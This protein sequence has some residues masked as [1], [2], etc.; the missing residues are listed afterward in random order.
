MKRSLPTAGKRARHHTA[1]PPPHE[2]QDPGR[3]VISV[4]QATV[5]GAATKLAVDL[6]AALLKEGLVINALVAIDEPNADAQSALTQLAAAGV[7]HV[8]VVRIT[9]ERHATVALAEAL[10]HFPEDELLVVLGNA[11][12]YE[13]RPFFCVVVNT[14]RTTHL[15]DAQALRARA[16]L[17][18]SSIS[19]NL[20]GELA[21]LLARR[22][23]QAPAE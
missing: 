17:E 9:R 2:R 4:T 23:R 12:A 15:P 6:C 18:L 5:S 13:Y 20:V 3:P 1:P 14:P 8:S 22:H 11:F 7:K 16:D 21:K 10:T 19:D